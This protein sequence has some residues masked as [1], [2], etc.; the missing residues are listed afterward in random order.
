MKIHKSGTNTSHTQ[1][2]RTDKHLTDTRNRKYK[3]IN[4]QIKL[5]RLVNFKMRKKIKIYKY[6]SEW[7]YT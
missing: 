4:Y 2:V 7:I 6:V 1:K 5:Y 3:I